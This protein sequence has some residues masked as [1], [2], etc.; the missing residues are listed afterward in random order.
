[1]LRFNELGCL[2]PDP[3]DFDTDDA[4]AVAEAKTILAKM[5]DTKAEMDALLEHRRQ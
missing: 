3:D 4:V 2:L 5:A 1:M